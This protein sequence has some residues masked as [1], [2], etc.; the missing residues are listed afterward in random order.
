MKTTL[1]PNENGVGFAPKESKLFLKKIHSVTSEEEF[2]GESTFNLSDYSE[3]STKKQYIL[4]LKK[5]PFS[6]AR[7]EF[8]IIAIP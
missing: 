8:D 2:L 3:C 6:E 7:I 1:E 5:S 4:P